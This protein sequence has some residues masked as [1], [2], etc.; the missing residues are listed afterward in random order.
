MK[1]SM[2]EVDAML[3]SLQPSVDAPKQPN[4]KPCM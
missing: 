4:K 3:V 2:R 1:G